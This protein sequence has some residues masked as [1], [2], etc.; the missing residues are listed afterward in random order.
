MVAFDA[1]IYQAQ[2][3]GAVGAVDPIGPAAEAGFVPLDPDFQRDDRARPIA[4][5][6]L[7]ERWRGAAIDDPDRQVPQ[8]IDDERAGG[9]L[10]QAAELRADP[11]QYRDRR[12]QL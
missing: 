2:R 1:E 5:V 12:K 9:A 11:R 10:Y 8:Q 6:Q 7:A 3:A 4:R